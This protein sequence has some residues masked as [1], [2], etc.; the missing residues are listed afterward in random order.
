MKSK[1]A[2][3]VIRVLRRL[4]SEHRWF[5]AWREVLDRGVGKLSQTLTIDDE[6]VK[7]PTNVTFVITKQA[8]F[9]RRWLPLPRLST[10][11]TPTGLDYWQPRRPRDCLASMMPLQNS[12]S[13]LG[14]SATL[15]QTA[16]SGQCSRPG[17]RRTWTDRRD[18][19]P[20]D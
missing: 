1:L 16:A 10:P 18:T 4:R 3:L 5:A 2:L 7:V 17:V 20:S 8:G 13:V 12:V 15:L 6:R 9:L 11:L 19:D 14:H